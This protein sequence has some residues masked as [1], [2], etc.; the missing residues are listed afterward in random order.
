MS[1]DRAVPSS[2]RLRVAALTA[3]A[4]FEKL[5]QSTVGSNSQIDLVVHSGTIAKLEASLD[6]RNATVVLVDLDANRHEEVLA[7]HKLAARLAGS[8]PILVVAEGFNEAVARQMLQL[9]IADFLVKP[10]EPNELLRACERVAQRPMTETAAEAQILT[11][12][13]ASGGVGVTTLAIETAMQLVRRAQ[14][15]PGS[16]CL[17]DLDIQ[18]GAV[19]H[20]LDIDARLDVGEI[21][22]RPERLDA[23]LLEVMLSHHASGL[24]VIAAPNR[25]ADMRSFDPDV[26][27]RL[28]DMVSARFDHVVIDMPRTWFA[29]T[30]SV[31]F[32]SNRLFV[33]TEM[34]VPGLRQA[35]QL[36]T[37]IGERLKGGPQP[38]VIVNRFEQH[39]FSPGLRRADIEQALGGA[40]SGV[41]PNNYRLVREAIDRGVSLDEVKAGS[42]VAGA[43]KKILWSQAGSKPAANRE[44]VPGAKERRVLWSR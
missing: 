21:E 27:T 44:P 8:P 10:V 35:K 29:W 15:G 7:L 9:R 19:A 20:Y 6:L 24:A 2:Q 36:V 30:D 16:I 13:S 32:G 42:N 40:F 17:V 12:L 26:V 28:L 3:D 5:L 43:L 34:T 39:L 37:A 31:L 22:P 33:V 41:I 11:F 25:P 14:R 18:H 4:T 38:Q 23:Q 1:D